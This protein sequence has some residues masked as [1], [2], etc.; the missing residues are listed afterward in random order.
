MLA[1]LLV[2]S[3]G[4]A[5]LAPQ[6]PQPAGGGNAPAAFN[7]LMP[8]PGGP[9]AFQRMQ[10][11]P[12]AVQPQPAVVAAIQ[13]VVA[14]A[15]RAAPPPVAPMLK[16]PAAGIYDRVPPSIGEPM[17]PVQLGA[18][19]QG[20]LTLLERDK[21]ALNQKITALQRQITRRQ[22]ATTAE[23]KEAERQKI[24]S[25]TNKLVQDRLL[26]LRL[27]G[28]LQNF[29]MQQTANGVTWTH[30]KSGRAAG[31]QDLP[32]RERMRVAS[33]LSRDMKQMWRDQKATAKHL[34]KLQGQQDK[35]AQKAVKV[36]NRIV[37]LRSGK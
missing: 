32:W 11:N 13:R 14:G 18:K 27:R 2:L 24:E 36:N 29:V 3:V 23:A 21:V 7:P 6:S 31:I 28:G 33:Q 22:A 19:A 17:A 10:P 5:N 8:N 1:L 4:A 9:P 12:G 35:A 34:K 20:A 16:L 30:A 37:R 26:Q 15:R 25:R